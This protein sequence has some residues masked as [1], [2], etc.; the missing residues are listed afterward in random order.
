MDIVIEI[1]SDWDP[2]ATRS[3]PYLRPTMDTLQPNQLAIWKYDDVF[4]AHNSCLIQCILCYAFKSMG[5]KGRG[6]PD[7]WEDWKE[8]D[9]K[10]GILRI[11]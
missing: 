5:E 9:K 1:K 6:I 10:M 11:G 2:I 8:D 7:D 3:Q 4:H